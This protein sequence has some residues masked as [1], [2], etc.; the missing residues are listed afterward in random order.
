MYYL[1]P[2]CDIWAQRDHHKSVKLLPIEPVLPAKDV[3]LIFN[4]T[5]DSFIQI[6]VYKLVV[7]NDN[8]IIINEYIQQLINTFKIQKQFVLKKNTNFVF[9]FHTLNNSVML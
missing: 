5:Y 4:G 6:K 1:Y 3:T 7:C 9:N 2:W 8:N